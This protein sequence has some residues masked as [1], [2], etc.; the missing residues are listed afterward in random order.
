M[1]PKFI[2]S[3]TLIC[4]DDKGT[5]EARVVEEE[6]SPWKKRAPGHILLYIPPNVAKDK[7]VTNTVSLKSDI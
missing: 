2:L 4:P 3:P 1:L 5:D 7:A 6:T